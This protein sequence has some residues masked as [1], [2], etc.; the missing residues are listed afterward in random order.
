MH[1]LEDLP[2]GLA[3]LPPKTLESRLPRLVIA[4]A[5]TPA[6]REGNAIDAHSCSV[7]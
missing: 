7:K 5:E 2:M 3:G 1:R 4:S 6:G